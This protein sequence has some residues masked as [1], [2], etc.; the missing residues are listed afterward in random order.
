MKLSVIIPFYADE[1]PE[2]HHRARLLT[3][4]SPFWR[5]LVETGVIHEAILARDPLAGQPSEFAEIR[6]GDEGLTDRLTTMPTALHPWSTAR[7]LHNGMQQVTGDAV[8]AFGADQ[9]PDADVLERAKGLLEQHAWMFLYKDV[10]YATEEDTLAMLDGKLHRTELHFTGRSGRCVGMWAWRREVWE[11][12]GGV[13][14]RFVGWGYGD[15]AWND[16]LT[17][18]YGPSPTP[19]GG[20][21]RELWH[22]A[23]YR[24]A[25]ASNPNYELYSCE[26]APFRGDRD[27]MLDMR[28]RWHG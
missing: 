11:Q 3:F 9:F 22:P 27:Y 15:D 2:G 6:V 8:T 24:D 17:A 19:P 10:I 18:V 26:Y 7:A 23:G 20:D 21:L 16:V 4:L 28:K 1:S 13:D 14:P 25:S 12:T 5:E